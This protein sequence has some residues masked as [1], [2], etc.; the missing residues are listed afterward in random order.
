VIVVG[1]S[2]VPAMTRPIH[3]NINNTL[4]SLVAGSNIPIPVGLIILIII[5]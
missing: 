4:P 5:I 2:V 1:E 3:G